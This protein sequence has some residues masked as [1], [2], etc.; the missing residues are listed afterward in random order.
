MA[1][2]FISG[3]NSIFTTLISLC[4][5]FLLLIFLSFNDDIFLH[6]QDPGEPY[7]T[8]IP[9][10]APL[11]EN[12]VNWLALPNLKADPFEHET[13]GDV[14]VVV[15]SVYRG[16]EHWNL[17]IDDEARHETLRQIIR[18]N[19]VDPFKSAGRLFAPHYRQA[20]LYTYLTTRED[21][22]RA[23]DFAYQDIQRAFT[24]FLEHSPPERPI[25]LAGHGQGG[26]HIQR[27][28][29]DFFVDKALAKRL[30]VAYITGHPVP[31]SAFETYLS[32]TRPCE[33]ETDTGCV[34]AFGAFMPSD[35]DMEKHFRERALI[36]TEYG[37]YTPI[38]N[39][40]ILCIN[41]LLWERSENYAPRRIHKGGVAA[42]GIDPDTTPAPLDQQTSAQCQDGTLKIDTP[43]SRAL[44]RPFKFGSKFRTLP[45]NIF[46]EDLR[47]NAVAR[48]ETRLSV[49]DLPKRAPL[50]D[51]LGVIEIIDSPITPINTEREDK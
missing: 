45:S 21:A 26:S 50:L 41:P 48:M 17:P 11:Y 31:L 32:F 51:D 36:P 12:A 42:E 4:L 35:Q 44:R 30:S 46:Y 39:Q 14:F 8:Y 24:F 40:E 47:V 2:H 37:R 43:K 49:G 28:L 18:P 10:R 7:Q 13:P 27:L 6:Y 29:A 1:K 22:K 19:Y 3:Q 33:A 38:M 23:Q 16:G 25:I 34:V 20:S 9:P 5:L 15:P